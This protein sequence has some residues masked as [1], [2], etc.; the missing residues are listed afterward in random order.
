MWGWECGEQTFMIAN[1]RLAQALTSRG[2]ARV[3]V[4][5]HDAAD[6]PPRKAAPASA[7]PAESA[8]ARR[9]PTGSSMNQPAVAEH[10]EPG[11]VHLGQLGIILGTVHSDSIDD[12]KSHPS[13]QV[14]HPAV[15]PELIAPEANPDAGD[16]PT[17]AEAA[18]GMTWALRDLAVPKLWQEGLTGRGVRV[19]H[20]DTGIDANHPALAGRLAAFVEFDEKANP[21]PGV[22]AYDSGQHGT[23]TAG[24]ICGGD[25]DG[26]NIGVAPAVELYCCRVIEYPT[27]VLVRV[28]AGMNWVLEQDGIRIMSM[29]FGVQGYDPFLLQVM[30]RVRARGILPVVAVGN[31]GPGTSRSPGNYPGVLSVGASTIDHTIAFFSGNGEFQRDADPSDPNLVA[32][33]TNVLSAKAGGGLLSL[34]GTSQATPHVAGIAALLLERNPDLTVDTL[35]Q[36]LLQTCLALSTQPPARCGSGLIQPVAALERV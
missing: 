5:L 4:V 15:E 18:A 19:A 17:P 31:D 9:P 8:L 25:Y 12:V 13:V 27:D 36:V 14:V 33:G 24:T 22:E 11:S 29:S 35:E 20:L 30:Q 1:A 28:L 6:A 10:L 16:S 3:V 21:L 34:M 23:H 26:L 7:L 2:S 32:P